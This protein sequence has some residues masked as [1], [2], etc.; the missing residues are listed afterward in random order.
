MQLAG[1]LKKKKMIVRTRRIQGIKRSCKSAS[2]FAIAHNSSVVV[3]LSDENPFLNDGFRGFSPSVFKGTAGM[4]PKERHGAWYKSAA[5]AI[6][7]GGS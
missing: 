1:Y 7:S 5:V 4:K 6:Q 2:R 3:S